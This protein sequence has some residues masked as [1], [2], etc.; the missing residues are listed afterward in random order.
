MLKSYLSEFDLNA[1]ISEL[2]KSKAKCLIQNSKAVEAEYR[3]SA[4]L[5]KSI[6]DLAWEVLDKTLGEYLS[7]H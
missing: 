6:Y 5:N 3:W 7:S 1:T 2:Q 4:E